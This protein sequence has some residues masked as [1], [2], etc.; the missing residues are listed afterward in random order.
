MRKI[1]FEK[2]F[3]LDKSL[4]LSHQIEDRFWDGDNLENFVK[5]SQ[6]VKFFKNLGQAYYFIFGARLISRD[7]F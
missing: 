3:T 2:Y 4:K 1:I 5:M 7:H 6:N